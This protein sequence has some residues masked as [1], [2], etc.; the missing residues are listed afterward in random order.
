MSSSSGG[1]NYSKST[2]SPYQSQLYDS[3]KTEWNAPTFSYDQYNRSGGGMSSGDDDRY[4]RNDDRYE[5]GRSQTNGRQSASSYM[6]KGK[7]QYSRLHKILCIVVAL[8]I[9]KISIIYIYFLTIFTGG[10]RPSYD[11]DF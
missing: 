3:W 10:R 9:I 5:R 4:H 8:N 1:G 7:S 6:T 11:D 2:S